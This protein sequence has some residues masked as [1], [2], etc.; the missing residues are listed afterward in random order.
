MTEATREVLY[1][2]KLRPVPTATCNPIVCLTMQV[3]AQSLDCDGG[4]PLAS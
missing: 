1:S 2:G 3:L 4:R